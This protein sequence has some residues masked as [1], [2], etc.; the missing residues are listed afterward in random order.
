MDT[1]RWVVAGLGGVILLA[2]AGYVLGVKLDRKLRRW[3]KYR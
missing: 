1:V 2:A 3:R